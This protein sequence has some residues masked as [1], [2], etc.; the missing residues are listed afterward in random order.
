MKNEFV[1]VTHRAYGFFLDGAQ[2]FHLHGQWQVGGPGLQGDFQFG[3]CRTLET[4]DAMSDH[5]LDD[6]AAFA[7]LDV[8]PKSQGIVAHH[9]QHTLHVL[10]DQ[11]Q[12]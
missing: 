9:V 11:I 4:P 10:P 12:L 8:R 5:S 7:G 3:Q 1:L 6:V 2:Q